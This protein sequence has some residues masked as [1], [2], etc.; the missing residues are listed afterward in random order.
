M[1]EAR[2]RGRKSSKGGRDLKIER[3][4]HAARIKDFE[5]RGW[6]WA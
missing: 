2:W 1:G 4:K 6:F 5:K 3:Q